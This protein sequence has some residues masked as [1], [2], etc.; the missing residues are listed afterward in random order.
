MADSAMEV[1]MVEPLPSASFSVQPAAGAVFKVDGGES[2]RRQV[3]S[4]QHVDGTLANSSWI[5]DEVDVSAI[6]PEGWHLVGVFFYNIFMSVSAA[7]G[8]KFLPFVSGNVVG[9]LGSVTGVCLWFPVDPWTGLPV[10]V[11]GV[12]GTKEH[13]LGVPE[14]L[15]MPG[16]DL[17][18]LTIR[19]DGA[20]PAGATGS[21]SAYF[22]P[23]FEED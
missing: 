17:V 7:A 6:T 14:V 15:T 13:L 9:Y 1:L 3:G 5:I 12:A 23:I 2:K 8:V 11:E 10:V 19:N 4:G 16:I 20:I 21:V 22:V 18:G